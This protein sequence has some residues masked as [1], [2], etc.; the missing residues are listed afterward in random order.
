MG[1]ITAPRG[2]NEEVF[3]AALRFAQQGAAAIDPTE[4]SIN[5]RRTLIY[6]RRDITAATEFNF[7]DLV[8]LNRFVSNVERG[9]VSQ[10]RVAV[11]SG[12]A[13]DVTI[14]RDAAGTAGP[15]EVLATHEAAAADGADASAVVDAYAALAAKVDILRHGVVDLW[16]GTKK[17]LDEEYVLTRFP[18][19]GGLDIGGPGFSLAGAF[20]A[21][22]NGKVGALV[23]NNGLPAVSNLFPMTP[24]LLME[25]LQ[26][27][28]RLYLPAAP[29]LPAGYRL[30]ATMAIDAQIFGDAAN[31]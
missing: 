28:G 19:P 18:M 17:I 29:T 5:S 2:V 16:V 31:T 26:L 8:A 10:G 14:G 7:F 3:S 20:P 9:R 23:A 25:N 4:D 21:N 13:F 30:T 22:I 1:T 24:T 27:K 11:L 12:F 15:G 6:C